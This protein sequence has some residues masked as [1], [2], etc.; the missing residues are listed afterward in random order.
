MDKIQ[1]IGDL[2]N[3][4]NHV[5]RACKQAHSAVRVY[6]QHPER[7][8]YALRQLLQDATAIRTHAAMLHDLVA[9]LC[10][11]CD[12]HTTQNGMPEEIH[13]ANVGRDAEV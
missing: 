8:A 9:A 10:V 4:M 6:R 5:A 7:Y 1:E 13:H 3:R 12:P 2:I 11:A